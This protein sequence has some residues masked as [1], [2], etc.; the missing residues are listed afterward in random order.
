MACEKRKIAR[1]SFPILLRSYSQRL[2][3]KQRF[4][5]KDRM[6]DEKTPYGMLYISLNPDWKHST[7]YGW[8]FT[9]SD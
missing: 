9:P 8:V 3:S 5:S 7:M 4:S 2:S 6:D 1:Y